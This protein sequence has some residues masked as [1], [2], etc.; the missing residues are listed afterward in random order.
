MVTLH[1][2]QDFLFFGHHEFVLFSPYSP[3]TT[4][5]FVGFQ[6]C[7]QM[8]GEGGVARDRTSLDREVEVTEN[9]ITCREGIRGTLDEA[10][11]LWV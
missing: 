2:Q 6:A 8:N 5:W 11:V 4:S 3:V 1:N 10:G 9:W 7:Y